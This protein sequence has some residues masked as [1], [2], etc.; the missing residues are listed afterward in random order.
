MSLLHLRDNTTKV[1]FKGEPIELPASQSIIIPG[2]CYGIIFHDYK[3]TT[4][5]NEMV[6][7][8]RKPGVFIDLNF[9]VDS[10]PVLSGSLQTVV[11]NLS[12]HVVKVRKGQSVSLLLAV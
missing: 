6:F 4:K 12:N 8:F 1:L 11:F 3:L 10:G 9:I 5:P 2:M 7:L